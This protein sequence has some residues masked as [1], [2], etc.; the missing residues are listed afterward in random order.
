MLLIPGSYVFAESYSVMKGIDVSKYQGN[1]DWEAASHEIDF[2]IIRCGFGNDE[3]SQDDT[4]WRNNAD[5]CTRLGIPFGVYLYSYATDSSMAESEANHVLRLISGYDL[6]FPVFLD[7]E[8]SIQAVLSK[9]KLG[10]IAS[11]FCNIIQNAGYRV[12]I[13][14]NKHWWENHLTDTAF[15]N[16]SW[17]KWVAQYNSSC[18]YAGNYVMWQYTSSGSVAGINGRTDMNYWY[19]DSRGV[20]EDSA[21]IAVITTLA[22]DITSFNATVRGTVSYS[23]SRPSE[24]GIYFG[25]SPDSMNRVARDSINHNKNPF[26]MWYD[27]NGEAGQYLSPGATYYWQCYAIVDGNETRGEIKSFVSGVTVPTPMPTPK[28]TPTSE[29]VKIS[30]PSPTPTSSP[31]VPK[32]SVLT[33]FSGNILQIAV[34]NRVVRFGNAQPFIDSYNRTQVP[35]RAVSEMLGCN[36]NWISES[37]TVMI[38][39]ENGDSVIIAVGSDTM[40]INGQKVKMDTKAMIKDDRT[41]IPVRFVAESLGLTVEWI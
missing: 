5:E 25:T 26:D 7:M 24:V 36:V 2:A 3:E 21:S 35:V 13:Y 34:D 39:R 19:G 18:T 11:T 1:I 32:N 22:D 31:S 23:G 33:V 15:N 38:T 29:I 4:Q 28:P 20:S 10:D 9:E 27:L 37:Q 41:Y 14:A 8:D 6:S 16:S 30:T 40:L 12:G 17:Y